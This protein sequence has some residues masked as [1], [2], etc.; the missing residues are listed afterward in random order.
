ME[1][2]LVFD[3]QWLAQI[4]GLGCAASLWL[5]VAC[6]DCAGC[7]GGASLWLTVAG[8]D[9]TGCIGRA[10]LW[11]TVAGTDSAGCGGGTTSS[12]STR[13]QQDWAGPQCKLLPPQRTDGLH[14]DRHR[15]DAN[16]RTSKS[17]HSNT[18]MS[19]PAHPNARTS[20]PTHS[21][22]PCLYYSVL[23]YSIS[24]IHS[25]RHQ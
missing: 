3:L 12:D 14:D 20:Q 10:S 25:W 8:T 19:Q 9:S 2:G 16:T 1:A 15:R 4:V 18:R 7:G 24:L 13:V 11:L 6:T 23:Y 5:T 21:P 22:M 17:T